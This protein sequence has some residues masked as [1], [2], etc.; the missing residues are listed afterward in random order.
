MRFPALHVVADNA[1][2][3]AAG[4]QQTA[5][6]LMQ[7]GGDRLALHVR[8]HGMPGGRFFDAVAGLSKSAAETGAW[9][10]INDRVDVALAGRI[11]RVLVGK[12][13]L[14]MGTVRALMG[15]DATIG[16]SAHS[17]D[18]AAQAARDT[19]NFV[20]LGTIYE[21]ASHPGRAG[22]GVKLVHDVSAQ[23]ALPVV[24]IG[25]ITP[26]RVSEVMAAGA[27]GVAVLRGV[28]HRSDAEAA[29]QEYLD[30]FR[31]VPQEK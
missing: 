25:G 31:R 30:A 29:V 20:M 27:T 13:S 6:A 18:E 1:A 2:I 9:L 10:I 28:W 17:A 11:T 19:A 3:E 24:A 4:F 15:S 12:R 22:S 7:L 26:A 16:Y 5:V 21:T 23:V 8:A 14:P